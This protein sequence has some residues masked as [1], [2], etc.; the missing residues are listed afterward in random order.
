MLEGVDFA[1]S[2]APVAVILSL[3]II[4]AIASV[5]GLILFLFDISN[6]FNN[7]ILTNPAERFYLILPYR[8]LDWYQ[9]KQPKHPLASSN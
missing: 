9:R 8:Y 7:T 5:E 2:Y 1:V 6:E 4:I 3:L